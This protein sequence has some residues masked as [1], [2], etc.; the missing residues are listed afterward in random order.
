MELLD[1]VDV[2]ED[3]LLLALEGVGEELGDEPW[4]EPLKKKYKI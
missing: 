4:P 3:D 1:F 2:V